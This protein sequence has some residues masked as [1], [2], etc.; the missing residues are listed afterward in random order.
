MCFRIAMSL[1]VVWGIL[2]A[3]SAHA[4]GECDKG[5][6]ET[7]PTEQAAMIAAL[8]AASRAFP[9]APAG[10][11]NPLTDDRVSPPRSV[12]LDISPWTYAYTRYYNR[13]EGVEEVSNAAAAAGAQIQ[14]NMAAKQPQL[15][16]LMAKMQE[17]AAQSGAAAGAGDFAKMAAIS[18]EIERISTEYQ[19]ILDEGDPTAKLEAVTAYF[20]N[21]QEIAMTVA[22]NSNAESPS[23]NAESLNVPGAASAYWY[24]SDADTSKARAIVLFGEWQ[25]S[26]AGLG[27]QP[28]ARAGVSPEGVHTI[29]V[30]FVANAGRIPA[31]I[32]STDFNAMAALL[33]R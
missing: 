26:T 32:E 12:C 11:V 20:Y 25:P 5:Y 27:L 10:W 14:A 24:V 3:R 33:S 30:T 1:A 28:V 4:D 31:L 29:G 13:V 9:A 8:D 22:V 19:R 18:T 2:G 23:P 17:L 7:T 15:D 21:D 16:A 6:H